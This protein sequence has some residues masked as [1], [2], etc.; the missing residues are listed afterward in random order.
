MRFK[1]HYVADFSDRNP[2]PITDKLFTERWSPRAFKPADIPEVALA[3]IFDA[4]RW[5]PSC[6]NEQPWQFITARNTPDSAFEQFLGLLVEA[7]QQWAKNAS[8]LGFIVAGKHFSRNGKINATASF[9]CGAAWMAMTLQANKFGLFTHGMAGIKYSEVYSAL[10][11]N[12]ETHQVICGFALGVLDA[13]DTLPDDLRAKEKPS[14]RKPLA[15]I[16]QER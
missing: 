15:A 10:D 7:N 5:S 4:A 16:W 1:S 11:I 2:E 8:L 13:P 3:A 14:P 9:D 12:P 6:F